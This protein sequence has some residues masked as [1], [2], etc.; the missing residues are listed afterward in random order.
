MNRA[1]LLRWWLPEREGRPWFYWTH[2]DPS[3]PVGSD[4][5]DE[6]ELDDAVRPIVLW[7]L[8]RGWR[9]TPSCEG[10]FVGTSADDGIGEAL[11]HLADDGRRFREGTLTLRDSETE[12]RIRPHIPTWVGP[13]A[14]ET[15]RQSIANNG[16]G[17]IGF[18]P[19]VESDWSGLAIPDWVTVKFDGPLVLVQTHAT[20]PKHVAPLWAE[21]GRRL[22]S[23]AGR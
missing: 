15:R 3:E 13:D 14:A 23:V 21:V 1:H 10:H 9:T 17:C 20:A 7:C 6:S 22:R 4:D 11:R 16:C 5:V 19:T 12:E 8:S 2:R 18:V